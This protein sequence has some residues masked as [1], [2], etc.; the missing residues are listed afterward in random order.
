MKCY[1]RTNTEL[2]KI[3]QSALQFEYGFAPKL[4]EI[5]LLE[6]SGD[7]TYILFEVNCVEYCFESSMKGEA[8]IPKDCKWLTIGTI[9]KR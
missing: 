8:D 1:E 9:E 7:G 2:K 4:K 5:V 3:A 6:A